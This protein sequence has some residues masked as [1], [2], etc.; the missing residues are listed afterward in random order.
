[1]SP[2]FEFGVCETMPTSHATLHDDAPVPALRIV[3]QINKEHTRHGQSVLGAFSARASRRDDRI[4]K[5]MWIVESE[6]L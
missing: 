1:M 2:T 6:R 3:T 4:E 5:L